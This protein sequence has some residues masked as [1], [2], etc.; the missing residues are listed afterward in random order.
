M[1]IAV[2]DT[3]TYTHVH[4]GRRKRVVTWLPLAIFYSDTWRWRIHHSLLQTPWL[5]YI[6]FPRPFPLPKHILDTIRPISSHPIS[7]PISRN[8]YSTIPKSS[9]FYQHILTSSRSENVM[10][11]IKILPSQSAVYRQPTAGWRL[12][13]SKSAIYFHNSTTA[14]TILTAWCFWGT[15]AATSTSTFQR[16]CNGCVEKPSDFARS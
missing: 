6:T 15:L 10:H 11:I 14:M 13:G 8:N 3:C 4:E 1:Q 2:C 12:E 16:I 5:S 9:A 7:S